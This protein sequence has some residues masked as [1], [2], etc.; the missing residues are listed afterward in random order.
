MYQKLCHVKR[1]HYDKVNISIAYANFSTWP[2]RKDKSDISGRLRSFYTIQYKKASSAKVC[3]TL[4]LDLSIFRRREA[5]MIY[6]FSPIFCHPF[7]SSRKKSEKR[8]WLLMV[9]HSNIV[10]S[11]KR[12]WA[13]NAPPSCLHTLMVSLKKL[14]TRKKSSH[15]ESYLENTSA[16]I[17]SQA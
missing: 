15:I 9:A 6:I 5:L 14:C 8:K 12:L 17:F 1:I 16:S 3:V 4:F 11:Q 2:I 7:I 13:K 10:H